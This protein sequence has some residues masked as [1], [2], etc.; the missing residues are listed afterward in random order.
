MRFIAFSASVLDAPV[1]SV[2][3]ASFLPAMPPPALISSTANSTPLRAWVPSSAR[4]PVSAVVR[5]NGIGEGQ[6]AAYA[7][8]CCAVADRRRS[9]D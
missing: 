2:D 1:S 9:R 7:F 5:P 6:L 3:S 4:L 8:G